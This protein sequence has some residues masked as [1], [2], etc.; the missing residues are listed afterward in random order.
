MASYILDTL[1]KAEEAWRAQS[2]EWKRKVSQW[3]AWQARQKNR[4][5]LAQRA[6]TRKKDPDDEIPQ[7]GEDRPWESYFDPNDPSPQFSFA[8]T[9]A[10]SK[11][12]LA[13][14]IASLRWTSTPEFL[15]SALWRGIA[16]HHSGLNKAYRVLVE[17]YA[18]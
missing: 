11:E 17:R 9:S 12:E 16:V 18:S 6:A 1:K 14:D 4:D 5:R 8:A 10:Y 13:E 3:E 2:P 7:Q 15:Y